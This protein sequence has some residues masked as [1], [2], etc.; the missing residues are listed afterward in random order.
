MVRDWQET[1]WLPQLTLESL[2]PVGSNRQLNSSW[3]TG[4]ESLRHHIC[5]SWLWEAESKPK[6]ITYNL[7]QNY[8]PGSC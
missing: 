3:L 7:P 6:E 2:G 1:D 5:G 4:Q 8:N